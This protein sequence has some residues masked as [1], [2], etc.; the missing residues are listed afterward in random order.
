MRMDEGMTRH[1][2][3]AWGGESDRDGYRIVTVADIAKDVEQS[4]YSGFRMWTDLALVGPKSGTEWPETWP[5]S[6]ASAKPGEMD[7]HD[8]IH[9]DYAIV[10]L[11]GEVLETFTTR[12]DGRA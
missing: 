2:Y 9:R 8:Y 7:D 6:L 4:H 12:I 1:Q 3:L 11:N 5:V 10:T